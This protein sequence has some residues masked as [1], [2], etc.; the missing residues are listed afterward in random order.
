MIYGHLGIMV[1]IWAF[2]G[3]MHT[4]KISNE[5]SCIITGGYTNMLIGSKEALR[6][7]QTCLKRVRTESQSESQTMRLSVPNRV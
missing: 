7:I 5:P 1:N 2:N 3:N 4:I 6:Q